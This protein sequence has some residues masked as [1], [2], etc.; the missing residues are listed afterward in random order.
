MT[1]PVAELSRTLWSKMS[2]NLISKMK[3]NRKMKME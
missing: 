3:E 2:F 1:F